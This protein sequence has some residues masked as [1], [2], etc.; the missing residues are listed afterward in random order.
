MNDR[1]SEVSA[2]PKPVRIV[3]IDG[4]EIVRRGIEAVLSRSDRLQLVGHV[5]PSA[6]AVHAAARLRPEVVLVHFGGHGSGPL[7]L[8]GD[9]V[10]ADPPLCVVV[11]S[12]VTDERWLFEALRLG[13]AGYILRSLDGSQLVESLIRASEGTRVVDPNLATRL[14]LTAAHAWDGQGWPGSQLGLTRRQSDVLQLLTEGLSNR[15]IADALVVG[16]ETVK[17]H[18]RHIYKAL[19]VQDR[20]QAVA[21]ALRQGLFQA[22]VGAVD[23]PPGQAPDAAP[24][25][26]RER[27]GG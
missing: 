22:E 11:L 15:H 23:A 14:A 17:T 7:A 5:S 4:D 2:E 24:E 26:S 9:L 19:G 12:E 21:F 13:V 8:V 6:D 3:L 25:R 10:S 16:E 27:L 20:T 1:F 18:L